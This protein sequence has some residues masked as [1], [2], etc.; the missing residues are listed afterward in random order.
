ML[1]ESLS[2]HFW[3]LSGRVQ[4]WIEGD[5]LFSSF[6]RNFLQIPFLEVINDGEM[7]MNHVLIL[8]NL[9]AHLKFRQR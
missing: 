4:I 1:Y 6:F 7:V 2:I 5:N 8:R 9:W 3:I